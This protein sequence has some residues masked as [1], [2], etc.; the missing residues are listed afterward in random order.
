MLYKGFNWEMPRFAHLPLILR[1]DGKGKL[2]KRDGDKLGI[3]VFSLD[4]TDPITGE[5]SSGYREKGFFPEAYL[6]IL[7][8]LG[9]NPG[10]EQELFN[11]PELIEAFSLERVNKAGARFNLDKAKW[12]N[13]QYLKAKD[14]RVILDEIRP[15]L[16]AKGYD[17]P[18]E[19]LLAFVNMMKERAT[20]LSDFPEM[21]YYFFEPVKSYEEKMVRKKW[22]E[23]RTELFENLVDQITGLQEFTAANIEVEVKRFMETHNFGFGDVLPILRLSVSGTMQGPPIYELMELLG[24]QEVAG[25][26]RKAF[27]Y[28]NEVAAKSVN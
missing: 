24:A 10:T 26:M 23:E 20:F 21:G 3:P 28:F 12:Y 15:F 25:R 5:K 13:Q 6:N 27:P 22:K 19:F 17:A 18:E 2:S 14:D 16:E 1:P 11:L 7:A 8:F 9:W 4:W